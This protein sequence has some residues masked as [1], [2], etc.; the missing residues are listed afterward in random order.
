[1]NLVYCKY[2]MSIDDKKLAEILLQENYLT[3]EI[4]KQ[5]EERSVTSKK[6][7]FADLLD[8]NILSKDLIGQA[9][10][11]SFGISYSDLNSHQPSKEDVLKIPEEFAKEHRC[12]FLKENEETKQV[13]ITT[14]DPTQELA[15]G[16]AS[17][18]PDKQVIITYS[19]GEDID[20]AFF[21]YQKT[22]D[23]RF[24]KIIESKRHIAP[25]ILQ[26]I[27]EDAFI[28]H[29]SDIHFEPRPKEVVI[30]FR[31]DGVLH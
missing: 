30:R 12:V 29:A 17:L 18:F 20:T 26:Q 16:L 3:E 28:F 27:F 1:M 5:A 14:D 21:N 22:L 25:E 10:A 24:S 15:T 6:T 7:L 11:E 19:L 23:T 8:Q 9:I 2:L 13:T 31:V 4:I